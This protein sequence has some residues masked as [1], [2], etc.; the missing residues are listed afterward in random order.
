MS[1]PEWGAKHTCPECARKYYDFGKS[2]AACPV[3]GAAQP[4]PKVRK[5]APARRPGRSSFSHN[6][7][8]Y[9]SAVAAKDPA[10][11]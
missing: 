1:P 11:G 10:S 9:R 2:V 4:A 5:A 6:P 3:C 7:S 8:H